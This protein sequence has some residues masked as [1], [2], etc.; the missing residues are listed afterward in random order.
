MGMGGM[1]GMPIQFS[2]N[3]VTTGPVDF[4]PDIFTARMMNNKKDSPIISELENTMADFYHGGVKKLKIARKEFTDINNPNQFKPIENFIDVN[5]QPGIPEHTKITFEN[6]GDIRPNRLPADLIFILKS[7]P[8]EGFQRNGSKLIYKYKLSL[9]E[10]LTGTVLSVPDFDTGKILHQEKISPVINPQQH[11]IIPEKG[12]VITDK[13]NSSR[14]KRDD[15]IVIFDTL[16][17]P[18]VH[19]SI[20]DIK[21]LL[22]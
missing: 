15:L 22:V 10:M 7:K 9:K 4:G 16:H 6:M 21:K 19:S 13:R 12:F 8:V 14:G 5:I 17:W 18:K 11:L 2:F 20:S 3:N 1:G